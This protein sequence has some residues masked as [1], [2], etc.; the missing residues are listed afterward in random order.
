MRTKNMFVIKLA[1]IINLTYTGFLK[2]K[3]SYKIIDRW[4]IAQRKSNGVYKTLDGHKFTIDR[5]FKNVGEWFIVETYPVTMFYS[6][7]KH[8]SKKFLKEQQEEFD[9]DWFKRTNSKNNK[10]EK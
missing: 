9:N 1:I 8:L 7:N 3:M 2:S 4:F 10:S 6:C 5:Y